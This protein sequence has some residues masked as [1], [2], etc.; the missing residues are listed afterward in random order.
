VLVLVDSDAECIIPTFC[1]YSVF[2]DHK[3]M[4]YSVLDLTWLKIWYGA[5]MFET[6]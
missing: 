4:K 3:F 1:I 2:P 6:C 5:K